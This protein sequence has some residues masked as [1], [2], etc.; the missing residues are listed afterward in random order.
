M[1][2]AVRASDGNVRHLEANTRESDLV[3][4]NRRSNRERGFHSQDK[5]G[6]STAHG[7]HGGDGIEKEVFVEEVCR[8]HFRNVDVTRKKEAPAAIHFGRVKRITKFKSETSFVLIPGGEG[9][10]ARIGIVGTHTREFG[11]DRRN[12]E[13]TGKNESSKVPKTTSKGLQHDECLRMNAVIWY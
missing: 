8:K 7:C 11:L 6:L 12:G 13:R 1:N 9:A 5:Q 4:D 10:D 2:E 3:A